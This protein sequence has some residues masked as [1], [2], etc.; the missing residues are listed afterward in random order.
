MRIILIEDN[1]Q[2][3]ELIRSLLA[4]YAP[5]VSVVG[6]A[7]SVEAGLPLLQHTA[8]E[9]WL[10]DIELR[11]G[12]VFEL[13][14]QLE[15]S[16]LEEHKLI[17]LTAFSDFD[18]VV[19][20]LRKS[21]VD[22]L[23]KPVDPTQLQLALAKVRLDLPQMNLRQKL[24][25]I[26]SLMH[27]GQEM[28]P[29]LFRVPMFLPKSAIR[30]VET[31][32]ILYLEGDENISIVYTLTNGKFSTVRNLGFYKDLLLE[33][34]GFLQISKK[35]LVNSRHITRFEASEGTV[36]LTDGTSLPSSR[37]GGQYL[38]EY[39]RSVFR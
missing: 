28:S 13:L 25:E 29:Q 16:F 22:Y 5:D 19:Q 26:K 20:A 30:Y 39:F 23:L 36:E 10:L 18:Y 7:E 11:D 17:F 2:V 9:L 1:P 37:R 34:A 33:K 3:R 14:D 24:E 35:Y 15:P 31:S 32:D 8:A 6:E 12:N 4:Q 27:K 21:A 38:L